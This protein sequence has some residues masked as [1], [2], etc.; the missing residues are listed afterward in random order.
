MDRPDLY[1]TDILAWS[2]EQAAVLRRLAMRRD[3]PDDLDLDNVVEEIETVERNEL[4]AAES[5]IRLILTH[6]AKAVA[7]PEAPAIPHWRTECVGRQSD[8][9]RGRQQIDA[10]VLAPSLHPAVM[11]GEGRPSTPLPPPA[12]Q[13]VD[14]PPSRTMTLRGSCAI[15]TDS[16]IYQQRLSAFSP[17]M[18]Q[19]IDM[20]AL[21]RRAL[22][23]AKVALEAHSRPLA[24]ALPAAC[25]VTLDGLRSESFDFVDIVQRV[26]KM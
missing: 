8:L 20:D 17:S 6:V 9:L 5:P 24:A 10:T 7:D 14:G 26:A 19:R 21:W 11:V 25:P 3:L 16:V 2:E 23:Q 12:P 4:R 1:D 18:E 15:S 13:G 22:R